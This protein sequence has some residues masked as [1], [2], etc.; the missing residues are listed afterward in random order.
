MILRE[1]KLYKKKKCRD[2]ILNQIINLDHTLWLSADHRSS[3]NWYSCPLPNSDFCMCGSGMFCYQKIS[4]CT[5]Q[6]INTA[7]QQIF[8]TPAWHLA[9]GIIHDADPSTASVTHS[10]II[11]TLDLENDNAYHYY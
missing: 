3:Q 2:D 1:E 10:L 6:L 8:S 11:H 5:L 7:F 9:V 4:M